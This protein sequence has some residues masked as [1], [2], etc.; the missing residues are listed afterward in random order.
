MS[1]QKLIFIIERREGLGRCDWKWFP[2][3]VEVEAL[4]S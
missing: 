1:L 2:E 3:V 4:R